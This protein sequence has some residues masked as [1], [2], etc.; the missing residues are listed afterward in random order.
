MACGAW[1]TVIVWRLLTASGERPLLAVTVK[2][3]VPALVGVPES[4]PALVRVSPA[5]SVPLDTVKVGSG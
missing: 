4:T 2:V 3:E 5:G 1:S